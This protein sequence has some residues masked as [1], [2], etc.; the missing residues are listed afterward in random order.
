[1]N[2]Q[3]NENLLAEKPHLKIIGVEGGRLGFEVR[4]CNLLQDCACW[5]CNHKFLQCKTLKEFPLW[6]STEKQDTKEQAFEK[7]KSYLAHI[8]PKGSI[9]TGKAN[10]NFSQTQERLE[11]EKRQWEEE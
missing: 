9:A 1:M 2:I 8:N 6:Y 10:L 4:R 5:R 7:A 11:E 3:Q